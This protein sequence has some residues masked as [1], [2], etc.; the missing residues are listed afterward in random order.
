MFVM[1]IWNYLPLE[2]NKVENELRY[3]ETILKT[4]GR[5][6][7]AESRRGAKAQSRDEAQR[8]RGTKPRT[9]RVPCREKWKKM[10]ESSNE[11]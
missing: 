11:T 1:L 9:G 5:L 10:E 6:K 4:S 2:L 7:R 8:R 3:F